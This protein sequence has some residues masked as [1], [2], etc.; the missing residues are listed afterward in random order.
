VL[1]T[2]GLAADVGLVAS[3]TEAAGAA[4][5]I[6]FHVHPES[7]MAG[8]LGAALWGAFRHC[9]LAAQGLAVPA[10]KSS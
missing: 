8:A 5:S 3:L 7:A 10:G 2:G 9:K 4:S 1:V 6:V